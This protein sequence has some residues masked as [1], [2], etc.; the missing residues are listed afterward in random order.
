MRSWNSVTNNV[1]PPPAAPLSASLPTPFHAL[2]QNFWAA[3]SWA[4]AEEI[5]VNMTFGVEEAAIFSSEFLEMRRED[6]RAML[7]HAFGSYIA[8]G[9]PADEVRPISCSPHNMFLADGG[10]NGELCHI[11]HMPVNLTALAGIA[12]TLLDSLDTLALVAS[13]SSFASAV[14]LC[15]STSNFAVDLNV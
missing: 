10:G 6:V 7:T 15:I 14:N 8:H 1:A 2:G 4:D 5:V 3:A 13:S 9:F 11:A 12:M